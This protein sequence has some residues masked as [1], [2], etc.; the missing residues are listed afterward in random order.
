MACLAYLPPQP[1]SELYPPFLVLVARL[2]AAGRL[3]G[4]GL[5]A[6]PVYFTPL[7]DGTVVTISAPIR[8][9][10]PPAKAFERIEAFV[11]EAIAPKLGP[12]EAAGLI[13][14][15]I[16]RV[17]D[18]ADVPDAMLDPYGTAFGIARRDQPGSTRRGS[19]G[20]QDAHRRRPPSGRQGR[21]RPGPTR[22]RHRRGRRGSSLTTHEM[23]SWR[24]ID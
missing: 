17:F 24:Q 4:G 7:D 19:P 14:D 16:G 9:G 23:R 3:G 6:S 21:F 8:E 20:H 10:E 12:D 22:R 1:G 5:T 11:A 15:E 13:E 18:L 2:W